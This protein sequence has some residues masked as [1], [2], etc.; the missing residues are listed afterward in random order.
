MRKGVHH[1]MD[2]TFV[3]FT[4]SPSAVVF[5]VAKRDLVRFQI[6][7]VELPNIFETSSTACGNC[8]ADLSTYSLNFAIMN[9]VDEKVTSKNKVSE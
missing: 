3:A 8:K 1:A 9:H 4:I 6:D 2:D 7:L 5:D